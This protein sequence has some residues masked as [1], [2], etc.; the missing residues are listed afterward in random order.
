MIFS[1]LVLM[2]EVSADAK[3]EAQFLEG[4]SLHLEDEISLLDLAIKSSKNKVI[5]RM[6]SLMKHDQSK[7]RNKMT[8]LKNKKYKNYV[9]GDLPKIINTDSESLAL[10]KLGGREFDHAFLELLAKRHKAAIQAS[11]KLMPG[12]ENK[13]VHHLAVKIINKQGNEIDKLEKLKNSL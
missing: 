10:Q 3:I 7:D 1:A 13:A 4:M 9:E 2:A 12:L 8:K 6:A 5:L 11:S